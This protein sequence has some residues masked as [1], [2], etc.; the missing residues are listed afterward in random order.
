MHDLEEDPV[1]RANVNIYKDANKIAVETDDES[2]SVYGGVPRI[3]LQEIL[4]DL[5][6]A[7]DDGDEEWEDADDEETA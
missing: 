7:D 3:T 6:V 5:K 4:D 1:S 2:G